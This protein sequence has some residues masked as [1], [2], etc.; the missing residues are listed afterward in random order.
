MAFLAAEPENNERGKFERSVSFREGAG[1]RKRKLRNNWRRQKKAGKK[2]GKG[3]KKRRIWRRH[4][5][6]R[7][8]RR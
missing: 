2:I 3:E 8:T 1:N 5:S 6:D 7:R 4:E